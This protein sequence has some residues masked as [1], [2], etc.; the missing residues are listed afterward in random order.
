L[1]PRVIALSVPEPRRFGLGLIGC[2]SLA[3]AGV[4]S[5][6]IQPHG[7]LC[8]AGLA[9]HCGWCAASAVFAVV[10]AAAL[11]A[12]AVVDGRPV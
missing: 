9:A 1:R 4:S 3:S 8:S 12:A 2:L 6:F 7:A 5:L 11:A 10:G